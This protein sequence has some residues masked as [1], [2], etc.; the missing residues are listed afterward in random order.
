[1]SLEDYLSDPSCPSMPEISEA[2]RTIE[3]HVA[4]HLPH[5]HV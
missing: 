4:V 1:M 5:R 2:E 3:T